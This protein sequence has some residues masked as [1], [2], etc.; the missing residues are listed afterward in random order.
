MWHERKISP[1]LTCVQVKVKRY[2]LFVI[3]VTLKTKKNILVKDEMN[4]ICNNK[5]FFPFTYFDRILY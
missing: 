4:K 3:Y 5:A 2:N 1:H